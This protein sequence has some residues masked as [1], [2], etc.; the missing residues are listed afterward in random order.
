[1]VAQHSTKLEQVGYFK[2]LNVF[3][4][5]K[6]TRGKH[7]LHFHGQLRRSVRSFYFQR[8]IC[9]TVLLTALYF[10]LIHL[11]L[12]SGVVC[13]GGACESTLRRI[14]TTQ[15]SF[16][17][18]I[19]FYGDGNHHSLCIYINKSYLCNIYACFENLKLFYIR[20]GNKGTVR[21]QYMLFEATT[22][23]HF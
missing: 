19:L 14:R 6:F 5:E 11:R 10:D 7:I 3:L 4:D 8:K 20:C 15:H 22:S 17:T 9:Y 16:I 18:M 23:V 1:M 13:W 12:Y 21:D 2:Y